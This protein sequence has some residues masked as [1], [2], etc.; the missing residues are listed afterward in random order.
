[1]KK[2]RILSVIMTL[3]MVI[4]MLPST[5]F[6]AA[7]PALEG[8]LQVKGLAAVGTPLSADYTQVTPAGVTDDGVTFSWNRQNSGDPA[9]LTELSTEKPT[10]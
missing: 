2:G 8:K 3:L 6:A 1:M 10:R 5:V 9:D 7:V 4:S